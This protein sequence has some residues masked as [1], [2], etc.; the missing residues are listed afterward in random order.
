MCRDIIWSFRIIWSHSQ[1]NSVGSLPNDLSHRGTNIVSW[2]AWNACSKD[3]AAALLKGGYWWSEVSPISLVIG[4]KFGGAWS[5]CYVW[6]NVWCCWVL[7]TDCV[8]WWKIQLIWHWNIVVFLIAALDSDI[9][10]NSI[11]MQWHS[12][13]LS[14]LTIKQ[15]PY[16]FKHKSWQTQAW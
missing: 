8:F 6:V 2:G 12:S 11:K 7:L 1:G 5:K 14:K 13:P 10:P 15:Y 9:S 4:R 16:L 3:S